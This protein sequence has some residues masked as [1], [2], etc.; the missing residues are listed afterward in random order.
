MGAVTRNTARAKCLLVDDRTE[1]LIA[2][3]AALRRNDLD[4]FLAQ[5][6]RE[7]LELLLLHDFALAIVDVQMP[8]IDGFEL[9]ELMRGSERTRG[10][11]IIFVTAAGHEAARKF[12]GYDAGAVDFLVKPLDTKVLRYKVDVFLEL[13]KQ[14]AELAD[15]LLLNEQF[16]AIV[17]HDFRSPLATIMMTADL[18]KKDTNDIH[19]GKQMERILRTSQQLLTTV[20]ELLDMTRA[21]LGGGIPVM[22]KA[23]DLELIRQRVLVDLMTIHPAVR[24]SVHTD[25]CSFLGLF[26]A[27]RMEQVMTN[28][29]D[30]A[31][32][33]GTPGTAIEVSLTRNATDFQFAVQ[34]AGTIPKEKLDTLLTPFH[35]EHAKRTKANGLGLGL[36]IVDQIVAAHEGTVAV[37]SL[38]GITRIEVSLPRAPFMQLEGQA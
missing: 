25:L 32:A 34:N 24:F 21:R 36:Y 1:N 16:V 17:A 38:N 29:L 28:L 2:L 23:A 37:A 11:P 31:I 33:H 12:R 35:H 6:G 20:N 13:F 4:L 15:N 5:S 8:E 18:L 7:A 19:V 27:A 14:R 9:A 26:D 3:E 30:N 22:R 10:T